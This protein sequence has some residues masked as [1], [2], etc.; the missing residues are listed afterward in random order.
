[1]NQRIILKDYIPGEYEI[2]RLDFHNA[3]VYPRIKARVFSSHHYPYPPDPIV[4]FV[5]GSA[6]QGYEMGMKY[7][8]AAF[9]IGK[10]IGRYY[11]EDGRR[12][13]LATGLCPGYPHEAARGAREEMGFIVGITGAKSLDEHLQL[14]KTTHKTEVEAIRLFAEQKSLYNIGLFPQYELPN[15]AIELKKLA[16]EYIDYY[17]KRLQMPDE[18]LKKI[19]EDLNENPMFKRGFK[20]G[21]G[22]YFVTWTPDEVRRHYTELRDQWENNS[23]MPSDYIKNMLKWRNPANIE[24]SDAVICIG[25]SAGSLMEMSTAYHANHS[26]LGLY[27]PNAN[28]DFNFIPKERK[29]VSDFIYHFH[30]TIGKYKNPDQILIY[31]DNAREL[32]REVANAW[33]KREQD[34]ERARAIINGVNNYQVIGDDSKTLMNSLL[35]AENNLFLQLSLKFRYFP[36]MD[37]PLRK[38]IIEPLERKM[39]ERISKVTMDA[40]F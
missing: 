7:D 14:L 28:M 1:M 22:T 21:S 19:A 30:D 32:V 11:G 2:E 6:G 16:S 13:V 34:M 12:M 4:V 25:G 20:I 29:N 17:R 39:R 9:D 3:V 8:K 33:R 27:S 15:E 40:F 31:K 18:E 36:S 37:R 38:K 5:G 10:E 24:I 35:H 23:R 26:I